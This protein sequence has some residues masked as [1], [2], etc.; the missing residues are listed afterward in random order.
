[1]IRLYYDPTK[2]VIIHEG[3]SYAKPPI[4]INATSYTA[5]LC[6]IGIRQS[7][8]VSTLYIQDKQGK[9]YSNIPCYNI[10]KNDYYLL[11][12]EESFYETVK[13]PNVISQETFFE[14][15][16]TIFIDS[17]IKFLV[18]NQ[19]NF[20]EQTLPEKPTKI[21]CL[22]VNEGLLFVCVCPNFLLI[23]LYDYEDYKPLVSKFFDRCNFDENGVSL[24]LAVADNQGRYIR[25]HLSYHNGE[26]ITDE[27]IVEYRNRHPVP[28]QLLPYDFADSL[29]ADDFDYADN[30]LDCG[31]D[32]TARTVKEYF[33]SNFIPIFTGSE[34]TDENILFTSQGNSL[35]RYRFEI[36]DGKITDIVEIEE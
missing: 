29:L 6:P 21:R 27:R 25:E 33:G 13:A 28:D 22:E 35:H 34:Q 23:I 30:L 20:C 18:E 17:R 4:S 8:P 16:V 26:Y 14:H 1:M 9:I 24:E 10:G 2:Y 11:P 5:L 32:V 36:T 7:L 12:H 19:T 3:K 15:L 31:E